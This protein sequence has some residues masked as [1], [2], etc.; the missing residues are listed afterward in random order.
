MMKRTQ[1]S[2]HPTHRTRTIGTE[3]QDQHLVELIHLAMSPSQVVGIRYHASDNVYASAL[4]AAD[5]HESG[6]DLKVPEVRHAL[7][8]FHGY[9]KSA[10]VRTSLGVFFHS[11]DMTP[12]V[13]LQAPQV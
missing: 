6:I 1:T 13:G 10:T 9:P 11:G 12:M 5:L 4:N 3:S 7:L 2:I 8:S